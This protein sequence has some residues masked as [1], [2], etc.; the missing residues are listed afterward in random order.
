M[1]TV[2]DLNASGSMVDRNHRHFQPNRL[3]LDTVSLARL[4]SGLN[5]FTSTVVEPS[6]FCATV[7]R[8]A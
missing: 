6:T 8:V 2:T 1:R 4:P 7:C 5:A 3:V